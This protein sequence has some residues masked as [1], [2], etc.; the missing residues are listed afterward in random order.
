MSISQHKKFW[1]S[2]VVIFLVMFILN[3]LS[4]KS[5]GDDYVYSFIWEGHSLYVPLSEDARRVQSFGDIFKSLYLYFLTWGGR[6]LA[7][8]LAMFFLWMPGWLYAMVSALSVSLLVLVILW[9]AHEGKV[10]MDLSPKAAGFAFFFIWLYPLAFCQVL[11]WIDGACNYLFPLL[12]L[13]LFLLPY[14]RHYFADGRVE[15]AGWMSPAMF[16][17]GLLGGNSNENVVCW[18]G[19]SLLVYL[20]YCRKYRSL[21]PWMVSGLIGLGLGYGLLMLA[22]GNFLRL[23]ESQ[24]TLGMIY[25]DIK[26]WLLIV[27]AMICNL[28]LWIYLHRVYRNRKEFSLEGKEGKYFH[29]ALRLVLLAFLSLFIMLFSP[30]FPNRSTFPSLIFLIFAALVLSRL[31]DLC[32]V[33]VFPG[34]VKKIFRGAG[35]FYFLMTFSVTLYCYTG[36]YR[37][38]N[39]L[40]LQAEALSGKGQILYAQPAPFADDIWAMASGNHI[41]SI[42][43][44]ED[45]DHWKNVSFARYYDLSGV[46]PIVPEKS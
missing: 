23:H 14:I 34:I 21:S 17:L 40:I 45:P 5:I 3:S 15:Y 2:L 6:I 39:D 4:Q 31:S 13:L 10:S 33:P 26:H 22:P 36:L 32:G 38:M 24:E 44:D 43:F 29:L 20:V 7:Q 46:A 28:P 30:E 11:N 9:G 8:G 42:S 18:V 37:Y 19:L 12:F 27:L 35:A 41:Y 16:L 25:T 1:L